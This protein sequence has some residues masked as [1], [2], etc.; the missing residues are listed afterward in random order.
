MSDPPTVQGVILPSMWDMGT[1]WVLGEPRT[2]TT[3]SHWVHLPTGR[4]TYTRA[5]HIR[6]SYVPVPPAMNYGVQGIHFDGHP[7][8]V[9]FAFPQ[10]E[11]DAYE[12]WILLLSNRSVGINFN[13]YR[14]V[15]LES[16]RLIVHGSACIKDRN[17]PH[18]MFI[19]EIDIKIEV[20]KDY[21][22]V[23][24][25]GFPHQHETLIP[26]VVL[27]RKVPIEMGEEVSVNLKNQ[28]LYLWH[29]MQWMKP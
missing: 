5:D 11:E 19:E 15:T 29:A 22:T 2:S 8:V 17:C 28:I 12:M 10:N 18:V 23:E 7:C 4:T 20:H 24:V 26:E 25:T 16:D 14:G 21:V 3:F 13:L 1:E 27:R 9:E 6:P